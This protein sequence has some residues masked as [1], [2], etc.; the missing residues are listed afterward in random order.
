VRPRNRNGLRCRPLDVRPRLPRWHRNCCLRRVVSPPRLCACDP[1]RFDLNGTTR[2][3]PNENAAPG[4][5]TRGPGPL[6]AAQRTHDLRLPFGIELVELL[7]GHVIKRHRYLRSTFGLSSTSDSRQVD[8]HR[9]TRALLRDPSPGFLV[10]EVPLSRLISSCVQPSF[11]SLTRRQ[12]ASTSSPISPSIKVGS[13]IASRIRQAAWI[14]AG[15][16]SRPRLWDASCGHAVSDSTR[17]ERLRSA[18]PRPA[19]ACDAPPCPG[20]S[21]PCL[22]SSVELRRRSYE[23]ASCGS[24]C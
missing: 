3:D 14:P 16:R 4:R 5:R 18:R 1:E 10:R 2:I 6:R 23:S 9:S 11:S 20:A 24:R 15:T 17:S 8:L 21:C 13:R 12:I 19:P 22:T 7:E